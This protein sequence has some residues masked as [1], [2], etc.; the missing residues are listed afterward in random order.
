MG[1]ST[2][3]R[4][5]SEEPRRYI[6]PHEMLTLSGEL[7]QSAW[8]IYLTFAQAA[9]ADR[10][11][12]AYQNAIVVAPE[13][14]VLSLVV[15]GVLVGETAIGSADAPKSISYAVP[16]GLLRAGSN[17]IRLRARQRHRTDCTVQ[18][19]Y[20]LWTNIAPATAF[21]GMRSKTDTRLTALEDIQAVG[22]GKSGSTRF[23]VIA[24]A[25]GQFRQAAH[26]MRLVQSLALLGRMPNQVVEL[27]RDMPVLGQPGELTV[28]VGS[29][30]E[31]APLLHDLPKE[32][33]A[34][35]VA[36]FVQVGPD[37]P[38][39]LLVTGPHWQAVNEAIE[40]VA[41]LVERPAGAAR[42]PLNIGHSWLTDAPLVN[43]GE[44]LPFSR[45]GVETSEFS[46]RRFRTGFTVAVPADFYANAYGEAVIYLDAAYANVVKP[47]SRIDVYVNGNIASTMPIDSGGIIRHLPIKLTL[48][49]FQPGVNHVELEAVLL[50]QADEECLPAGEASRAPLF[51][52]FESSELAIPDYARIGRRPDLAATIGTGYP[53]DAGTAPIAL[54]AGGLDPDTLSAA[55]TFVARLAVSMGRPIDLEMIAS[56]L[57]ASARN[58]ILVGSLSQLPKV[59]L[60]QLGIDTRSQLSWGRNV[61]RAVGE[62][63]HITFE[64]WQVR[65]SEDVWQDPLASLEKWM[66]RRFDVS[67]SSLNPVPSAQTIIAPP[68]ASSLL[69]AQAAA[70]KGDATWTVVTAPTSA[71]IKSGVSMIV[72]PSRWAKVSGRISSYEPEGDKIVNVEAQRV[73]FV[74]TQP[75]S[76]QNLRLVAANWLSNNILLYSAFLV[77]MAVF[78]GLAT[79]TVIANS[80]RGQ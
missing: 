63:T 18:S 40:I 36:K 23:N 57:E 33:F 80:G 37:G 16:A 78:F 8:P 21:I 38:Q 65:L 61:E 39:V 11:T 9:A 7:A 70:P 64:A 75:P 1:E 41:E 42:D 79:A 26:M 32:A 14:S 24:P 12:F 50:T 10:I 56:P 71:L 76:F 73:E 43:G 47:G 44:T 5:D 22:S 51:A 72:E 49:H 13:S 15:N 74:N 28:L 17:E 55:A 25:M 6:L 62:G 27:R 66:K 48:R 29:S 52:L 69:L 53:Y 19:T 20:E 54:Y 4:R 34:T 31:L 46:G 77:G 59:V 58:A 2:A 68:A 60:E 3:S 35:S 67:V 30:D 45:L